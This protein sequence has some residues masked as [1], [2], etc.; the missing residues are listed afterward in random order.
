MHEPVNDH[1]IISTDRRADERTK[2][3]GDPSRPGPSLKFRLWL[4]G[5]KNPMVQ[6]DKNISIMVL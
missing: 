4:A 3:H 6:V 5:H 1:L 2:G